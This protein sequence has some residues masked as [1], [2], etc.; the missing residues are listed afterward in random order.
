[1]GTTKGTGDTIRN[2][3]TAEHYNENFKGTIGYKGTTGFVE[4]PK[5]LDF[6][7]KSFVRYTPES[8]TELKTVYKVVV[9]EVGEDYWEIFKK[10]AE[11]IIERMINSGGLTNEGV[12]RE[13]FLWFTSMLWLS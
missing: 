11:L 6:L 5:D 12:I 8:M 13:C 10:I 2:L 3:N 9:L 4:N 7:V 1:M